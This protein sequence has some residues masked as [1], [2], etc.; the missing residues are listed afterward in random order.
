MMCEGRTLM[1][2]RCPNHIYSDAKVCLI[3]RTNGEV[4]PVRGWWES[5]PSS[6]SLSHEVS[7]G[8]LVRSASD[9]RP[10]CES[11]EG[12]HF[13]HRDAETAERLLVMTR[14]ASTEF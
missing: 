3:R 8:V 9:N 5:Q 14:P 10:V 11:R 4:T 6:T 13:V 1:R 7:R 2:D 12:V